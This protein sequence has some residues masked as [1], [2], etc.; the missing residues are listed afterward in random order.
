MYS[1][2][3]F[4]VSRLPYINIPFIRFVYYVTDY[5]LLTDNNLAE[6]HPQILCPIIIKGLNKNPCEKSPSAYANLIIITDVFFHN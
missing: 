6:F 3:S 4:N 1:G 5:D 2:I